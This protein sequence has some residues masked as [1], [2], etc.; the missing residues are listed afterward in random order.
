MQSL[1]FAITILV[2]VALAALTLWVLQLV[3]LI[4]GWLKIKNGGFS[5]KIKSGQIEVEEVEFDSFDN[6][7]EGDEGLMV[8]I[9]EEE[10]EPDPAPDYSDSDTNTNDS[11]KRW[12]LWGGIGFGALVLFIILWFAFQGPAVKK[13]NIR[14]VYTPAT[15][16]YSQPG[17]ETS[18]IVKLL[19]FGST[20]TIIDDTSV[21]EWVKVKFI[22]DEDKPS[23]GYV[24]KSELMTSGDFEILRQSGF[25]YDYVQDVIKHP[26]QRMA[27]LDYFKQNRGDSIKITSPDMSGVCVLKEV[28]DGV[29]IIAFV[30]GKNYTED[31]LVV[32]TLEE[33]GQP[34]LHSQSE[35]SKDAEGIKSITGRGGDI[36]ITLT[37]K[38]G[39]NT[40]SM[41][42]AEEPEEEMI[43]M[44]KA[45]T[46][47]DEPAEDENTR[48]YEG[49]INGKYAI[50]MTLTSGGGSYYTGE[51][52]YTKNK[53]PIQLR[54]Q[55]TD[56]SRHL[57]LE[58]YVGMNMTGKFEG[59]LSGR[60]YYGTWTSADG[61]KSY[62]FEVKA[63]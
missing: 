12:M 44:P 55:L 35:M 53:T 32:Y 56:D 62:P 40:I 2:I 7:A 37:P 57:V 24:K 13:D 60:R 50:E 51:Y 27:V 43:T 41:S 15:L 34:A 52:F 45:S 18:N 16:A 63:K 11:N 10:V 54:G 42:V 22:P 3:Y 36:H 29:E 9:L 38:Q 17:E 23:V 5:R 33:D 4:M 46:Y 19:F 6:V 30:A 8:D 61:E 28:V 25:K 14:Y 48:V 59:T 21:G 39:K 58:E 1:S 26:W 31:V 49:M 47:Y 20:V